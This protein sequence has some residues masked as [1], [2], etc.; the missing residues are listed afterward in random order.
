MIFRIIIIVKGAAIDFL[1]VLRVNKSPGPDEIYCCLLWEIIA[2]TH[3]EMFKYCL[4]KNCQMT[5][6]QNIVFLL[7]KD[8]T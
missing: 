6:G 4:T 5:G 8:S 1:A 3:T 2:G 7:K